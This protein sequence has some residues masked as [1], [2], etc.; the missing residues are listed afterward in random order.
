[1]KTLL[2]ATNVRVFEAV[3]RLQGVTRAAEELETSQPYVSKQIALMETQLNLQLFS[4]VGRRLYLT[5]AGE[6]L[7][8]H[9]R[10]AVGSLKDAEDMLVRAASASQKR[11]R[12][13]TT[14]TGM[15]MLPEWLAGFEK[16]AADLETTLVVTNGVEVEQRVISGDV[17]LGFVANRPR[18]RV[19]VVDVVGEDSL[20]L[21]VQK[22]HPLAARSSVRLDELSRE[23]FIIREPESA[24]RAL[25]ERKV[26]QKHP[27]WRFRLQI[28][29]IDAIKSSIE[30]GLGIS[31]ISKRAIDRELRSGALAMVPVNGVDLRRPICM[32]SNVHKC[33][34]RMASRLA[35]HIAK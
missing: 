5:H 33:G 17:D 19:L 10:V 21:A 13:A 4:R 12:I 7:H 20:A 14:T 28:N 1:M 15:Y 2:T 6:L 3:A 29:H 24:S 35:R 30:E 18:S 26:F 32:L 23:R 25:T 31:F 16:R 27:D 8:E 9:A 22:D 34:S 11:I